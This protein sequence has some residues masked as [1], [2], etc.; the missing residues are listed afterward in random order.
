MRL[1][2]RLSI[3]TYNVWGAHL[4]PDRRDALTAVLRRSLP[5]ILLLQE[6]TPDIIACIEEALPSHAHVDGP[7]DIKGWS[8]ESQIFWNRE[9]FLCVNHGF[10]SYESAEYPYRGLF[11]ARLQLASHDS[12]RIVVSTV[13][14]PWAGSKTELET[15]VNMR[16]ATLGPV[17]KALSS[18]VEPTDLASFIGGDFNEDFHPIRIL[19]AAGYT[20]VFKLCDV[21]APITHPNRPSAPEEERCSDRTLDWILCSMPA[22]CRV[23]S[24]MVKTERGG[25]PPPSDHMPVLAV[26][27]LMR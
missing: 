26:L 6:V 12:M 5:D 13:H 18:I 8:S 20:D 17:V 21:R 19:N 23:L 15:G 4:W 10:V 16:V 27:E 9:T 22:T 11:W 7:G 24:C 25:F 2:A 1:M 14:L 3:M